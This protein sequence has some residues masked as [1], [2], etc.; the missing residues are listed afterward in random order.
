MNILPAIIN[1]TVAQGTT[2]RARFRSVSPSVPASFINGIWIDTAT[3]LQLDPALVVPTNL[4]GKSV[5]G[6]MRK[7]HSDAEA[8]ITFNEANNNVFIDPA[9]SI[10]GIDFT[11]ALTTPLKA[12]D[13]EIATDDDGA[14]ILRASKFVY[15]IE[16]FDVVT[17]EVTRPVNGQVTLTAEVT[18]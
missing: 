3:G 9:T 6:A 10:Y 18:K 17:G 14:V 11:P 16:I 5:R 2:Y 12:T 13:L 8:A 15:D 4:T 1:L 7:K